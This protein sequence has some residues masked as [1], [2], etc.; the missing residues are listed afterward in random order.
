[1]K[2]GKD[3]SLHVAMEILQVSRSGWGKQPWS[4]SKRYTARVHN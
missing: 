1:M 2:G 4:R 3:C